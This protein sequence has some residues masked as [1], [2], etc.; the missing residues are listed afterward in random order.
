MLQQVRHNS[1][2]FNA[3]LIAFI[4]ANREEDADRNRLCPSNPYA[5]RVE[6]W[7]RMMGRT[8]KTEGRWLQEPDLIAWLS[9][10]RLNLLGALPDHAEEPSVQ[11]AMT[12]YLTN[13][14]PAIKRL[15]ELAAV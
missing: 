5:T 15:P 9:R 3:A 10:T 1:P 4:E 2:C 11:A 8:W 6:D 7:P 12:R 13:V 14:A